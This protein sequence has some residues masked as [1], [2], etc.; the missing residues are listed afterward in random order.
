METTERK[1]MRNM[2]D[3]ETRIAEEIT[4]LWNRGTEACYT[5]Y[6]V[7]YRE[8]TPNSP[9][10]IVIAQAAPG[11]AWTLADPRRISPAWS[12]AQAQNLLRELAR[13]WPVLAID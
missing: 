13:R 5:P 7:W 6:Y 4:L 2:A 12:K 10:D 1:P 9:G 8:T 3:I 11:D